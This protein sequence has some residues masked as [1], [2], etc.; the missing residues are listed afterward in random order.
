MDFDQMRIERDALIRRDILRAA[1]SAKAIGGMNGRMMFNALG[2]ST[3]GQPE[4]D[5][6]LAGLCVDLINAGLLIIS[7][8]LRYRTSERVTLDKT[9]YAVTDKGTAVLAGALNNPLVADDRV[10]R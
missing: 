8:D 10:Q 7:K 6:H 5:H 3:G 4:D 1:D 9:V 2:S